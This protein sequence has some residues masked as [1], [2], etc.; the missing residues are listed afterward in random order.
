MKVHI[1]FLSLSL[2]AL[3]LI[4]CETKQDSKQEVEQPVAKEVAKNLQQVKVNIKGMTCEI[5][6]ARLI[7]SKLYKTDGVNFANVSFADSSGV[8]QFDENKIDIE[9]I[10]TVIEKAG[11][12]D[13]YTVASVEEMDLNEDL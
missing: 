6:C 8:I 4:T 12:G 5:G 7:Q 13:I 9:E 2:I 1:K 11:G 3:F 10:K